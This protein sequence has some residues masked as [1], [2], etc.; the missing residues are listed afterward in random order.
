MAQQAELGGVAAP[1]RVWTP[2][3]SYLSRGAGKPI[4]T[5]MSLIRSA[6][7]LWAHAT[8]LGLAPSQASQ[9]L[10]PALSQRM[11]CMAAS[12]ANST[13]LIKALR[14]KS[15]SPISDVKV[16]GLERAAMT[17]PQDLACEDRRAPCCR[18]ADDGGPRERVWHVAWLCHCAVGLP[19]D[20]ALF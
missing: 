20:A 1:W 6:S 15:G 12:A 5:E 9:A 4:E 18:G 8:A 11:R 10:M 19:D 2:R 16:R 14:E 7:A 17:G 13:A 3:N